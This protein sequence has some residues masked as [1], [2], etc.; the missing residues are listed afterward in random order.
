MFEVAGATSMYK[1]IKAISMRSYTLAYH[2][3]LR[4][5]VDGKASMDLKEE[6]SKLKSAHVKEV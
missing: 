2:L 1:W 3:E 6:T 5:H 4:E